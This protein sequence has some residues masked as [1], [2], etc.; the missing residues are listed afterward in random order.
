[1]A[2]PYTFSS[3]TSAIPLSQ[4]DSNFATTITLGNT[5]I[6]LGNTVTTLNNMTLA[7][8]TI[9]SVATAITPAQGGTGLTAA[10]T[11][12]NV[13]TSNGTAWVSQAAGAAT[14]NVTI[15]N[16]TIS[17]GG[18]ASSLGNVGLANVTITNY[19]ETLYAA[20]TG[21]AITVN[22]VN[23]TVQQLLMNASPTITMPTAVA[24]KSF[25]MML[26]QDSTGSRAVT[27]STVVWAGGTAPTVTSTA[28][29]Q[30]IY[31]FFSDGTSWFGV[32]VGQSY[33]Y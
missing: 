4:L 25:V 10:G 28:S 9:S 1:M 15:G 32:T 6:Q 22:L 31:S 3:A 17:L 27:W 8:V 14:G 7:N 21:S 2:V 24:G 5:A 30:D 29:K 11:N 33:S 26:R 13:L 18:T 16:T 23:G 19:T 20:N 12:G